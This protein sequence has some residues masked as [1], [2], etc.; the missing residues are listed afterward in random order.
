MLLIL[1]SRNLRKKVL[2]IYVSLVFFID[3]YCCVF[4]GEKV[5]VFNFEFLEGF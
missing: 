5:S 1:E 4:W 3:G 2:C